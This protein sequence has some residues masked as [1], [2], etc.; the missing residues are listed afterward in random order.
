L[1]PEGLLEKSAAILAELRAGERDAPLPPAAVAA[2]Q[3]IA[4]RW[5]HIIAQVLRLT[6]DGV[7]SGGRAA[8]VLGVDLVTWRALANAVEGEDPAELLAAAELRPESLES[9][10]AA[11]CRKRGA[12]RDRLA[13]ELEKARLDATRHWAHARQA[14]AELAAGRGREGRLRAALERLEA[15][16]RAASVHCHCGSWRGTDV[17]GD[18]RA[19]PEPHTADC[20]FATLAEPPPAPAAGGVGRAALDLIEEVAIRHR[21]VVQERDDGILPAGLAQGRLD[22]L[23]WVLLRLRPLAGLPPAGQKET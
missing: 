5:G 17:W 1:L 16:N 15:S 10:L 20:P 21:K 12:D 18:R 11:L 8:E 14:D 2:T 3:Q 23:E 4:E 6:E 22:E 13:G 19:D 7:I 9:K